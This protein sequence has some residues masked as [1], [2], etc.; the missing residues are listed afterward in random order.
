MRSG[1][2]D[3]GKEEMPFRTSR[4]LTWRSILV[5]IILCLAVAQAGCI[6]ITPT[7]EPVTIRFPAS[8]EQEAYYE[9]L[10]EAFNGEQ[11]HITVKLVRP[12]QFGLAEADIWELSPFARRFLLQ[13]DI[14]TLDLSPFVEGG[15]SFER[16]DFYPGLIDM[17]TDENKIWAMPYVVD[18]GV[19]Y[20]NRDLFDRYGVA[21]PAIDWTW[22]DF[23][24]A[25][26]AMYD[27]DAG[28][29]G[30]V[31]D[32]QHNDALALVYQNGGRIFDDLQNPTRTTFDDPLTIEALDW[33][34]KLIYEH[35]AAATPQ[36]ARQAYGIAGYTDI[37]IEQGRLGMWAGS[38]SD[39]GGQFENREADVN[40]GIV[41]LPRGR[42]SAAF[43]SASGYAISAQAE[44]PDACW[45]WISF[46]S[47]QVLP[48]GM[49]ARKS[50]TESQA[51]EDQVG[52]DVAA[53]ARMSIEHALFLSPAGWDVYGTFQIF[54][55]A[56]VKISN[57]LETAQE[58]MDWAQAK[59]PYQ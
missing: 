21:Y 23:L 9:S 57:D 19:M 37:G 5:L 12:Q 49:P 28:V 11:P 50:V 46:L 1:I 31:P 3:L 58:A 22:D 48:Y 45:E 8:A 42:Q 53:V 29:F 27:P 25:A 6:Q 38:L 39:P 41:P 44:A 55:E 51:Y 10:I 2:S 35:K 32:E 4:R 26:Q 52:K 18:V 47:R 33:Y 34:S 13:Q 54:D 59:S 16:Q 30:Y 20:Y 7:P 17:F 40:W 56:V 15:E 43:A 14:E 24:R 36:Q